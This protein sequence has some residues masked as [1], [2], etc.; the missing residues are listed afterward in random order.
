MSAMVIVTDF[1]LNCLLMRHGMSIVTG[2]VVHFVMLCVWLHLKHE[3]SSFHGD[4]LRVEDTGVLI[5]ASTR[6]V[7]PVFVERIKVVTPVKVELIF[8]MIISE[9]FDVIVQEVPGHI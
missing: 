5:K 9:H 4:I 3:V 7:P 8:L 6:F 2:M 1:S